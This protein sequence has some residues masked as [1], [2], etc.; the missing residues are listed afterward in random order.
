MQEREMA[1]HR[2]DNGFFGMIAGCLL[3]AAVLVALLVGGQIAGP[4]VAFNSS[5][6]I[7]AR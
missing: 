3:A 2:P 4:K 6:P 5:P 7:N 1:H